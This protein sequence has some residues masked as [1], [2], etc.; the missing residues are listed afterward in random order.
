MDK[1]AEALMIDVEFSSP[2]NLD[3]ENVNT[4]T[5]INS[6]GT[7]YQ[8]KTMTLYLANCS[9]DHAI[10]GAD[11]TLTPHESD[12]FTYIISERHTSDK[13]YGIMIDTGASKR[14]TAGYR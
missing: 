14:S 11:P 7:I 3:Q 10:T 4:N 12:S 6:F 5:F 9:F 13:F 2:S 1:E 8:A